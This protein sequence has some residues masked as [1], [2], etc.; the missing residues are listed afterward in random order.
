MFEQGGL[1]RPAGDQPT[2]GA[3]DAMRRY[4]EPMGEG[5]TDRTGR[6]WPL[7]AVGD[8]RVARDP[9]ARD[10]ADDG[11]D[12]LIEAR[13]VPCPATAERQMTGQ[14]SKTRLCRIS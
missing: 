7:Q 3:D 2:V 11:R 4:A 10:P 8:H 12:A 1:L 13:G 5:G 9:A 14:F 6:P